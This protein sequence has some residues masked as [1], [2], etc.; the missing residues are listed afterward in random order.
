[1]ATIIPQPPGDF[2]LVTVLNKEFLGGHPRLPIFLESF[3]RHIN[4]R[5]ERDRTFIGRVSN[6]LAGVAVLL[7]LRRE[8]KRDV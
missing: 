3:C 8:I 5:M 6:R 2:Y 1:M 7:G 4:S